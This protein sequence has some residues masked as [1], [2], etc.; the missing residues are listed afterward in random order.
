[1]V[2]AQPLSSGAIS[3]ISLVDAG[4]PLFIAEVASR[5]TVREDV[6]EKR[7]VY[8]AIS[9]QEYIVY[10]P[11]GALLSAPLRAWRLDGEAYI[12]WFAE[13]DGL[14]HSRALGVAIAPTQPL[15]GLRDHT[16]EPIDSSRR[17]WE[18]AREAAMLERRVRELEDEVRR[19][20]EG[21]DP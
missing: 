9:A 8:E 16:R 15:L 13:R 3:S 10:D 11:D 14:W 20:R 17:V 6:G 12:P 7:Q 5:S 19:L 18:R 21:S 2:L 4:A 1:M